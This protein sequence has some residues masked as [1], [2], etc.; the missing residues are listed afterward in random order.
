MLDAELGAPLVKE[1]LVKEV[2]QRLRELILTGR[3][4]P[5]Q[6]LR[7]EDLSQALGI[8]RTPLRQALALLVEEGFIHRSEKAQ[9]TVVELDKESLKELY[10]V[11]RELDGLA[12]ELAASRRSEQDLDNMRKVL[13][14]LE[15][16][17]PHTWIQFHRQFHL[18]VYEASQNA[19]LKRQ[20]NLVLLSI[21]R[22]HPHLLAKG[23]RQTQSFQE[24]VRIFE[25][26]RD[27]HIERAREVAR[28]HIT[29]PMRL[30]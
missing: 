21:Q 29:I 19:Y 25:A 3:L 18:L 10:M 9:Y 15:H 23:T 27:Q 12:A 7:Q 6:R 2:A 17:D 5:K 20:T 13:K 14:T 22:F 30:L 1:T 26:I 16:C 11:R 4:E 28:E 8:S 24:Q